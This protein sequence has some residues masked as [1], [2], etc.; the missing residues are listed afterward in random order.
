MDTLISIWNSMSSTGITIALPDPIL[1]VSTAIT[2]VL[3]LEFM[4][5]IHQQ[6]GDYERSIAEYSQLV[7]AQNFLRLGDTSRYI[8][9]INSLGDVYR[10]LSHYD[11]AMMWF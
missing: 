2:R 5:H 4:A 9:N 11:E 1:L 6:L 7:I 3:M 10:D 8:T